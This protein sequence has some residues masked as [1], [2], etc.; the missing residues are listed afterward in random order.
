[1]PT[2]LNLDI[3]GAPDSGKKSKAE[4]P[5]NP[6]ADGD[7]RRTEAKGEITKNEPVS[8]RPAPETSRPK[9]VPVGFYPRHLSLLDDAVIA[10]RRKRYWKASK[11]A[12]IRNLIDAHAEELDKFGRQDG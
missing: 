10:L 3:F 4:S 9:F 11:S 2:K 7:H 12:I 5:A 6:A 8:P 1:M